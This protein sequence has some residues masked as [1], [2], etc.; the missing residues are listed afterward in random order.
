MIRLKRFLC[1]L[2]AVVT[3]LGTLS[4]GGFTGFAADTLTLVAG[5]TLS[6]DSAKKAVF[7]V[8]PGMTA[9]TVAGNF[10][11]EA[12]VYNAAGTKVA[13]AT[14]VG[15]GFT[16]R[17]YDG[18]TLKD[19]LDIV[20]Y[21]DTTGDGAITTADLLAIT[22]FIKGLSQLSG[23][24]VYAADVNMDG[25]RTASDNLTEKSY[26]GGADIFSSLKGKKFV[27]S[28]DVP[29]YAS[30][31]DAVNGTSST[32]T[33]VKGTYYVHKNYPA[34]LNGMYYLTASSAATGTGFW[35]DPADNKETVVTPE[36][37][38]G[39]PY[40]VVKDIPKY[41]NSADAMNK[42]NST[43][44]VTAGT[45]YIYNGYPNG[46]NGMYNLTTDPTGASIG[47]WINPDENKVATGTP[48]VVVKDIPKYANS[49]DAMNKVNS[50]GTVTA[51]TY[52]IYNGYPTGYNGMYNISTDPTGASI[53]FW[54]NPDENRIATGTA[55]VVE[56]DIPKYSS[57]TDALNK[58]NSTGTV[59]A[60]TY[61]IYNKY[62][63][64]YNG[65][66][67]LSTD[68]T[69]DSA[70]F[71][72]NPNE[73]KPDTAP[74]YVLSVDIPKYSSAADAAAKTNSIG[75]ATAGTY[76]IYKAYPNGLSGMYN[77]TTDSTGNTAGFWINPEEAQG[78]IDP[79]AGTITI[80]R[81]VN[82]Y[83]SSVDAGRQTNITGTAA[84]GT[85]YIYKG[86]PNG[87]GGVYNVSTDPTGAT[88]GF[89]INPV[90]NTAGKL[91]YHTTKA[92]WLSQFDLANVYVSGASQ[93]AESTFTSKIKT[94]LSAVKS[95]GYNT[96]MV[97]V[98]PNGDAFYNSSLFPWSKYVVGSYGRI[99]NYDPFAIIEREAHALALSV[100]AWV[101]PMRLMSTTEITAL[102]SNYILK[103]WYNDTSKRGK[104]IVAVNG[105]YYLNPGYAETR[106]LIVD[107]VKEICQ[108]YNVDG[109]HFDDYF[110]PEGVTSS[111]DSDA[112][113]ASGQASLGNWRRL[114]V[115]NFV[116]NT[117]AAVK[118]IDEEILFGISPAGNINN[119]QNYL[120]ADVKTWCKTAGYVDYIAPQIYWGFEHANSP[121]DEVLAEWEALVKNG[122]V[123][124]IPA[125]TM[126]KAYG[127]TDSYDGDE[128]TTH[129]DVIKR[130]IV[131]SSSCTNFGGVMLF[132]L[133]NYYNPSTGSYYA[134]LTAERAN[135]EPVLKGLYHD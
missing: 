75:T 111:F 12:Y 121:F 91:N 101:N 113:K 110:Y 118:A 96:I 2:L 133:K 97:Q 11:G 78:G 132:S 124:L 72:I 54:I 79:S 82:K 109:I 122:P 64:G 130:Q 28:Y 71:W 50:T 7:N 86:Y 36:P 76:Y 22:T 3:V 52:Y 18:S 114:C 15:T 26:L 57:A 56:K 106:Q 49:A 85:Y 21:G 117:Y 90:E 116:M 6:V 129:K 48:Y 65:M 39:T 10:E 84:A 17:L 119:N 59:A 105:N 23:A 14:V 43:G 127:T 34:G 88:A 41:A 38:V 108:N 95:S 53:G 45:Y 60:G 128:W 46:Y 27:L 30:V 47:F 5:S 25:G 63:D 68:P 126:A 1:M 55:Y 62:P 32:G 61:Y 99:A 131:L 20:V 44:T 35:I 29:K 16:V 98:R 87:L 51:G 112:F 94:T 66:L 104:Y 80:V 58:T 123:Q 40:Q 120:Y 73:N 92:V 37:V 33:A 89:W 42:V 24:A 81:P 67:N 83:S 115:S 9:A 103:Q 74:T 31:T 70:G 8:L 19:S 135:F 4:F 107:G 13:D 69:G 102:S 77:L 100:H 125:I 93:M 134:N